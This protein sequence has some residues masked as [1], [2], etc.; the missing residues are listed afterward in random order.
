MSALSD[1]DLQAH[2]RRYMY[3]NRDLFNRSW[4]DVTFHRRHA[5]LLDRIPPQWPDDPPRSDRAIE[6]RIIA[7]EIRYVEAFTAAAWIAIWLEE[8]ETSVRPPM[9]EK[10]IGATYEDKF[11]AW[12]IRGRESYVGEPEWEDDDDDDDG[13]PTRVLGYT[14]VWPKLTFQTALPP[15]PLYGEPRVSATSPRGRDAASRS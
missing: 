2:I 14:Y 9:H 4:V 8:N 6:D 11:I 3:G 1:S 15:P 5:R 12:F 13:H 10:M 7:F